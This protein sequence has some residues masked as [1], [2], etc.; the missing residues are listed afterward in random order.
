[1]IEAPV[2]VCIRIQPW[3]GNQTVSDLNSALAAGKG[4][5]ILVDVFATFAACTQGVTPCFASQ[6]DYDATDAFS[7]NRLL[8][9]FAMQLVLRI[10]ANPQ[11]PRDDI[12]WLA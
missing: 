2:T 1:M 8:D 12:S 7:A 3:L 5:S 9:S 6:D 4:N 10:D 11:L